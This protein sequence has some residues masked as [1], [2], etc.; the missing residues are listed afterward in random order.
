[1]VAKRA[2]QLIEAGL[3][4]Q[5]AGDLNGAAKVWEEALRLDPGNPR[6]KRCLESL[7][8]KA[9]L[10]EPAPD[11]SDLPLFALAEPLGG[12]AR[13]EPLRRW[14]NPFAPPPPTTA[15]VLT[16]GP[17]ALLDG[18]DLPALELAPPV[19]SAPTSRRPNPF[20]RPAAEEESGFEPAWQFADA[21]HAEAGG[22]PV[23]P[24]PL[25]NVVVPEEPPAPI[26]P[27]SAM[28][29]EVR[30]LLQGARDL[31]DLDDHTGAHDTI[32]KIL[33]LD[34]ENADAKALLR[35]SEATLQAMYESKIGELAHRPR[36]QLRADEIV[37]L[38]IDSR[39]GF[40]LSMIDGELSY[41]D[42][43]ALSSMSRLETARIL[44]QLLSENVIA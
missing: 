17:F 30:T 25:V 43:F 19:S 6:A 9:R 40:L 29:A 8:E 26:D 33:A 12:G 14:P 28:E 34:P 21:S 7:Q 23:A 1:M 15:S 27:R 13:P 5:L 39:A 36:V 31:L 35:R 11:A 41:D 32:E 2:N 44:C 16:P 37:W 42:L 3:C 22:A 20:E 18:T 10:R 4:L 24:I 38:N